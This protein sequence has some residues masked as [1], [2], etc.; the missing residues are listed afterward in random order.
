MFAQ[1]YDLRTLLFGILLLPIL[2][3]LVAVLIIQL[4]QRIR[5]TVRQANLLDPLLAKAPIGALLFNAK[6]DLLQRNELA[7]ALFSLKTNNLPD[8]QWAHL[9]Q[10]DLQTDGRYRTIEIT[11]GE[12]T[13]DDETPPRL[14]RWWIAHHDGLRMALLF[15]ITNEQRAEQSANQLLSDLSHELRTPLATLLTHIEV[16]GLPDIADDVQKQSLQF[17][18]GETERL[19]RMS[20]R[21]LELGRIQ[22]STSLEPQPVD[23]TALVEATV[24][25]MQV[26]AAAANATITIEADDALPHTLG[27]ADQLRQVLINLIDNAIKYG[28]NRIVVSLRQSA[29]AITCA[30]RDN[31]SGIPAQQIPNLQRR[32]VRA[33][34]ADVEGSGLGLAMVH[35]ILRRHN[36]QLQMNSQTEGSERGTTVTFTLQTA[37]EV[38]Q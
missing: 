17:M 7:N 5:K 16:L 24:S 10:D 8:T 28:G 23:L 27:D 34:P 1:T 21:T 32:Y 4:R 18:K 33:A 2:G 20:N 25:Q 9:L 30:I 3:A 13:A 22:T 14:I 36:S 26:E 15:D 11:T 12:L 31:G 35:E 38:A 6:G 29:N 37:E 19:V